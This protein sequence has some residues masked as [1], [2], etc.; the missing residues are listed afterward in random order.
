MIEQKPLVIGIAGYGWWGKVIAAL[1]SESPL[2]DLRCIAEPVVAL[3]PS[4]RPVALQSVK[5]LDSY[6]ALIGEPGLEAVVICTP[7]PQHADQIVA[8]ARAGL[9]VFCEKPLCLSLADADRAIQA[10][11]D[12][13]R[14]LGI[15]HERR[16]EPAMQLLRQEVAQGVYGTTLQIEANFSQD[17]FLAL[18]KDNWR[19][20]NA[21]APVGPLTATGIHLLDLSVSFFG[22]PRAVAARL[23]A[24]GAG[25]ENGDTLAVFLEFASGAVSLIS[26]ILATPFDGRFA[27]Y[28]SQGWC[29][30][31][32][33]SHPEN[34]SGWDVTKTIRGQAKQTAFFEPHQA[35]R[36]NLESF[37][38]AVR[39]LS[40]YPV[41]NQQKRFT[42]AAL[43]AVMKAV[44]TGQVEAIRL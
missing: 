1:L 23:G 28:G 38:A 17:K 29:E 5:F 2:F 10:C 36:A 3:H 4:P 15:G 6:E 22:K 9:H 30:I 32:D 26:A 14:V 41:D 33:R 27:V 25:F 16:F 40:V 35:V 12:A 18:P 21:V 7:H 20:S 44:S 31:R 37:A 42:V 19:L 39:G 24:R 43:E 34:P 8:A 13:K 11:E